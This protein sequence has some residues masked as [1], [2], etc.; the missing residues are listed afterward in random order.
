M[1]DFIPTCRTEG[2]IVFGV[3]ETSNESSSKVTS[4]KL[5]ISDYFQLRPVKSAKVSEISEA[6]AGSS[7]PAD[8]RVN[9]HI[10]HPVQDKYLSQLYFKLVTGLDSPLPPEPD[11]EDIANL[12][13]AGWEL[14]QRMDIHFISQLIDKSTQL[15]LFF[16]EFEYCGKKFCSHRVL[17]L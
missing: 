1:D 9:F 16:G 10:G 3:R 14:S 8:E 7:I 13:D 11:E 2:D 5:N 15:T 17:K 4:K 6:T 12:Q